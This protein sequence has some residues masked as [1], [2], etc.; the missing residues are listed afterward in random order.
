MSIDLPQR[1]SF[2]LTRISL[3]AVVL[4]GALLTSLQVYMDYHEQR[5]IVQ[6]H[7][8]GLLKVSAGTAK[9]ALQQGDASLAQEVVNGL[10]KYPF[11]HHISITNTQGNVV[12]VYDDPLPESDTGWLTRMLQDTSS[13]YRYPLK[14]HDNAIAALVIKL[15]VDA[16]LKPL[17]K[18]SL[19][20][21][22]IDLTR[23]VAL[24]LILAFC[25]HIFL[26]RPLSAIARNFTAL[27]DG[28]KHNGRLAMPETLRNNELGQII[29]AAN[30]LLSTLEAREKA[31]EQKEA[32]LRVSLNA[33]P[34]QVFA[35]DSQGNFIFANTATAS[36]YKKTVSTLEGQN[37]QYIH[38]AIDENEAREI[39]QFIRQAEQHPT[40]THEQEHSLIDADGIEHFVHA[41]YVPYKVNEKKCVLVI[42]SDITARVEAENRI[43]KLAYFDTLTHLPNKQ[44]IHDRLRDDLQLCRR[45]RSYGALLYVDIDNFKRIN[46]TLGHNIGDIMLL[47]IAQRM[48]KQIRKS[49]TL[50]RLGGDEFILSVPNIGMTLDKAQD[51]VTVLATR[52]LE[53]IREPIVLVDGEFVVSAS[54]GVVLYP[55]DEDNI[56]RLLSSA[57]TAMYQAKRQGRDRFVVFDVRMSEEANRLV[58]LE[59]DLR[60]AINE[61]QFSFYLQ[62]QI[63]SSTNA[64]VGAEALL[65]WHH[66]EAGLV[67]ND[68]YIDFLQNSPMIDKVGER[69]LDKVCEF[70]HASR[71]SGV[72]DNSVRIAVNLSAREFY[73]ARFVSMVVDCLNK[74]HLHGNCLE[75]EITEGAALLRLDQTLDKISQLKELGISF[76][77]DDFGTGYSSLSYLKQLPIDK[78]KIDKSFVKDVTYDKQDAMLVASI[79]AIAKTLD[80][81]VVAEGVETEDQAVWLNFHGKVYFQGF[82]YDKPMPVEEFERHHLVKNP[83]ME[84]P[85]VLPEGSDT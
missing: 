45:S 33:S 9:L 14:D 2:N 26:T 22:G 32:Q 63:D 71:A 67:D 75:F 35:L 65:R 53:S 72:M 34:N 7:I 68:S 48:Q 39:T 43:E 6:S 47:K 15:N 83:T 8:Q 79:I 69:L 20:T 16:V 61:D 19:R 30:T 49:E 52:V 58:K 44:Q 42:V 18:R 50:A 54:I 77:L 80:L 5:K 38:S 76:A 59:S 57:D 64:I 11:L 17:Y 60:R 25:Y 28:S 81:E 66:P 70:I 51:L 62:P 73:Q 12:A 56:D 10:A 74:Y 23:T 1:L 3:A 31:L 85:I 40:L 37:F 27:H 4:L 78:I 82:L 13:S 84:L 41:Y 55:F 21:F 24:V 29:E 46:E 36:F